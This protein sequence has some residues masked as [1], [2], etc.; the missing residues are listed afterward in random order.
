[1]LAGSLSSIARLSFDRF[2]TR[3]PVKMGVARR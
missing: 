1:L 3:N 2:A